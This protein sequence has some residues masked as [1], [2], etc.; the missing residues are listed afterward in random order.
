MQN[1]TDRLEDVQFGLILLILFFTFTRTEVPCP[2]N[3]TGPESFDPGQHWQF[4]DF[5]LRRGPGGWVL[6]VLFKA[7]KQ[8]RRLERPSATHAPEFA[9]FDTSAPRE[10]KDWVP[11]GDV[12]D[13]IFSISSWFMKYTRLMNREREPAEAMFFARDGVRPYTYRALKEDLRRHLTEVGD[14]PSLG[15]HGIRVEG[16]NCS[17]DANGEEITV[18]H[19]GWMSSAHSRYARFSHASVLS[20]PARMTGNASVFDDGSGQREVNRTRV[21]RGT[22]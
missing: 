13:T 21:V 1:D 20:I 9:D 14:D 3:F 16:Y 12:P 19:G 5:K 4:K 2:K 10:S 22:S 18:A 7:I 17:K 11:I 8:D 15:P 6:W